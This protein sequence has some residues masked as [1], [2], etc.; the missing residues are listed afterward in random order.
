MDK[1]APLFVDRVW[2]AW[3]AGIIDGSGWV[4]VRAGGADEAAYTCV[5]YVSH[6]RRELVDRVRKVTA[7]GSVRAAGGG[8]GYAWRARGRPAALVLLAVLPFLVVTRKQA[9]LTMVLTA[10]AR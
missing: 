1:L 10:G 3:L 8:A 4:G 6:P 2:A 9:V 5:L 7:A